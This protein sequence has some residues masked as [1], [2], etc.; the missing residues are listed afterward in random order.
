MVIRV[1]RAYEEAS[2]ADGRRVLVDR[3][4][5]RGVR[6]ENAR[7]DA[8][9]REVAPSGELRKW[10]GHDPGRWEEFK[11]RYFKELETHREHVED[12]CQQLRSDTVT[13]LYGAKDAEHN[14]AIALREYLTRRRKWRTD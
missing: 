12:L 3:L 7:V 14:N 1:K 5:P 13:L 9:V 8:W 4:W 10:F 6:K 2:P 11:R